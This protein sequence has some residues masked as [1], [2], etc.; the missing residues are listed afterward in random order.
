MAPNQ[1]GFV[2]KLSNYCK[3]NGCDKT[4]N[5]LLEIDGV[6][7]T[8]IDA[9]T[10]ELTVSGPVDPEKVIRF[11]EKKGKKAKLI[12]EEIQPKRNNHRNAQIIKLPAA[13]M[14]QPVVVQ[15]FKVLKQFEM[16]CSKNVKVTFNGKNIDEEKLEKVEKIDGVHSL[17]IDLKTGQ[18][19]ISGTVDPQKV[20]R[21]LEKHH[22]Q[23]KLV[24]EE[25]PPKRNNQWEF[26][27]LEIIT[28]RKVTING[29]NKD[30]GDCSSGHGTGTSF[31]G[32]RPH[33]KDIIPR[34]W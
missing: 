25:I 16:T 22:K 2:L 20:I 13:S 15:E 18:M 21:Y 6:H 7:S 27:Q 29:K 11:L 12:T 30:E 4:L 10:G 26:E 32:W 1:K 3:C 14:P 5:K 19:T 31:S 33:G 24:P 17:S 34:H 8:N 9:K 28:Y 23:A